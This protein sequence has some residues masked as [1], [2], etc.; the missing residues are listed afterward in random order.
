M[1]FVFDDLIAS[2]NGGNTYS[3]F[4]PNL[5]PSTSDGVFDAITT[6]SGENRSLNILTDFDIIL[7]SSDFVF[8]PYSKK[9]NQNE[10][11]LLNLIGNTYILK[12]ERFFDLITAIV[13]S[14]PAYFYYL[15]ESMEKIAINQGLNK[16][17]SNFK[18]Y[19]LSTKSFNI[20]FISPPSVS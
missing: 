11:F 17:F 1:F 20:S 10:L 15:L 6:S 2:F 8:L 12:N 4:L 14:G 9:I 18:T 16:S 5:F 7:V 13:G 19:T 3:T